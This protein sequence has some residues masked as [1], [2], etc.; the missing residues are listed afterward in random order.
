[1]AMAS[2]LPV[3][4][5]SVCGKPVEGPRRRLQ[6]YIRKGRAYCSTECSSAFLR[7]NSSITMAATNRKHAAARMK[8]RNP[9]HSESSVLK[10]VATK[11]INGTYRKPPKVRGGNG[12]I[13]VVQEKLAKALGWEME[14]VV[15]VGMGRGNGYP[16]H[17]KIDI[18]EP[19]VMIAIEV[20]GHSHNNRAGRER[21]ARK[22]AK[23]KELGWQVMRFT[24]RQVIEDVEA[25]VDAVLAVYLRQDS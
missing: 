10:M 25:C 19:D 17:Y 8:D 9:M 5:C 13:S 3:L 1:M 6:E 11:T 20:D 4:H 21:D 2:V 16:T 15:V 7:A 22:D 24:N 14:H 18:A 23:L 12:K